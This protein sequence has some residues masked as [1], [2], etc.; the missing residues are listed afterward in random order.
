M[1]PAR[2]GGTTQVSITGRTLSEGE[3]L[4]I[5][6]PEV[7]RDG[8]YEQDEVIVLDLLPYDGETA[9]RSGE[10]AT[11]VLQDSDGKKHSYLL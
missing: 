8:R 7:F 3:S 10:P 1:F 2:V 6:S 11:I 9:L 4:L 5:G